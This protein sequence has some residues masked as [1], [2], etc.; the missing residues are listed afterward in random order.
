MI[1]KLKA[2]LLSLSLIS[3]TCV[4]GGVFA[5]YTISDVASSIGQRIS[6]AQHVGTGFYLKSFGSSEQSIELEVNS[7]PSKT[8]ELVALNVSLQKEDRFRVTDNTNW[9]GSTTSYSH[10]ITVGATI[11]SG[12]VNNNGDYLAVQTGTYD[13]YVRFSDDTYTSYVETYVEVKEV[14][15][16]YVQDKWNKSWGPCIHYWGDNVIT[17]NGDNYYGSTYVKQHDN[18][19]MN[20]F[21]IP[22][23]ASKLNFRHNPYDDNPSYLVYSPEFNVG[24]DNAF[25]FDNSTS[26]G[27]FTWNP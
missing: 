16:C 24:S 25:W 8:N 23:S 12:L 6:L 26:G 19:N 1:N 21:V 4:V 27:S 14:K 18:Y 7:D 13:V 20:R 15:V 9:Y 5:S 3:S 10:N 22:S 2:V 17:S 11:N